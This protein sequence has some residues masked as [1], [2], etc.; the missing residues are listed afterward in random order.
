MEPIV[1]QCVNQRLLVGEVLVDRSDR[2][3]GARGDLIGARRFYADLVKNL[4]GGFEEPADEF[5]RS[6]LGWRSAPGTRCSS[7]FRLLVLG[8]VTVLGIR[9]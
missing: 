1:E 6:F 9:G 8:M 5:D 7:G 4:S 3:A 2:D